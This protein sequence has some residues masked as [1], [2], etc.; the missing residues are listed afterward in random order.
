[1]DASAIPSTIVRKAI[2][3]RCRTNLSRH[4]REHK[5]NPQIAYTSPLS[6]RKRVNFISSFV[7]GRFNP[8]SRQP[9]RSTL[10][11]LRQ[12]WPQD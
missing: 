3:R 4:P 12:V 1:M 9:V 2:V 5:P 10:L 6:M 11:P 7:C 8:R